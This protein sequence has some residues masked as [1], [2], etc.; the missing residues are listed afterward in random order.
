MRAF[1]R[2]HMRLYTY[3]SDIGSRTQ[4]PFLAGAIAHG[5]GMRGRTRAIVHVQMRTG[6]CGE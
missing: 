3:K 4:H 2:M 1:T 5:P 6:E